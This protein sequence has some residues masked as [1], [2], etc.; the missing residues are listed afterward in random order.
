MPK[1]PMDYKRL[2]STC[3]PPYIT[4]KLVIGLPACLPACPLHHLR[5][6]L[7]CLPVC[8]LA[9]YI[10]YKLVTGLPACLLACLPA[11]PQHHLQI[12]ELVGVGCVPD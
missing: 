8:L 4:Y 3:L 7:A 11:C 5:E 12:S 2:Y 10:T 9:P 6:L 1:S